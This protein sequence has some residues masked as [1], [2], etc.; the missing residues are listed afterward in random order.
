MDQ[1]LASVAYFAVLLWVM[2]FVHELGHFLTAKLAGVKVEEFGLGFPPRLWAFRRG[3]TE[4]SINLLPLGGFVR[5]LGEED[6]SEPRSFAHAPKLARTIILLAGSAMNVVLAILLFTS[7]FVAG[8]PALVRS[9][10]TIERVAPD[11]PAEQAGV[12]PGDVVRQVNGTPI[13]T[14]ETLVTETRQRLGR[15]ITLALERDGRTLTVSLVPRVDPPP[16]EG[17]LGVQI[18]NRNAVVQPRSLPLGEALVRAAGQAGQMAAFTLYVPVL[19]LRNVLPAEAARPVGPI[20][21]YQVASQAV[22]ETMQ[23]GWWFPPLW[24]GGVLGVGLAVANLLPIPGLDG[25]RLLFVLIEALRGRRIDPRREG[26]VHLVG[27][28]LLMSLVLFISYRDIVAP[29]ERIDWGTR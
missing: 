16:G 27:M 14:S 4:Y 23:S 20:G 18:A 12:E 17:A 26:L 10:V 24:T 5:L 2:V 7:A 28:I 6:P 22:E 1:T 13:D 11:S 25:G 8:Y 9:D 29:L 15:S 21:I 3:E 19:V